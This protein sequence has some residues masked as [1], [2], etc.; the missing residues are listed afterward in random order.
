MTQL[1]VRG[2]IF[3][4][5]RPLLE[6]YNFGLESSGLSRMQ[7][8]MRQAILSVP[9]PSI[10]LGCRVVA[11]RRHRRKLYERNFTT[12]SYLRQDPGRPLPAADPLA[13]QHDNDKFDASIPQEVQNSSEGAIEDNGVS[14]MEDRFRKAK[15]RNYGSASRRVGRNRKPKE[16]INSQIP[17]WFVKNNVHLAARSPERTSRLSI[18]GDLVKDTSAS[19][20]KSNSKEGELSSREVDSPTSS[21]YILNTHIWKEVLLTVRGGLE[22]APQAHSESL[23]AR[24]SHVVL[25]CPKDGGIQF[26]ESIVAK[27][28]VEV[29]ADLITLD[30]QDIAEISGDFLNEESTSGPNRLLSL[31]YDAHQLTA[32]QEAQE[33]EEVAEEDEALEEEDEE[34]NGGSRSSQ[35]MPGFPNIANVSVIPMGGVLSNLQDMIR[36]GKILAG[37]PSSTGTFSGLSPM[38]S[39]SQD[40]P[41]DGDETRIQAMLEA[42]IS[43]A[44]IKRTGPDSPRKA[45]ISPADPQ[46]MQTSQ[47]ISSVPKTSRPLIIHVQDYKEINATLSGSRLLTQLYEVLQRRRQD[48][49]HVV[50]IGT[51]SSSDLLPALSK[52][53][54]KAMQSE[55]EA[56][57]SRTI[58]VI[59]ERSRDIDA[60]FIE[61]E[62][63]RTRHVNTR[64]LLHMMQQ[65]APSSPYENQ[66]EA[67][68][69]LDSTSEF[70]SGFSESVWPFDRV[71]RLA[72]VIIGAGKP[73]MAQPE[74][75]GISID[76]LIASDEVK[77]RWVSEEKQQEAALSKVQIPAPMPNPDYPKSDA[78]DKLKRIRKLCNSHERKLLSGVIDPGMI[79]L[80]CP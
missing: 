60:S 62:R 25:Q 34:E 22:L 47:E 3:R 41:P 7:T 77:Y 42:M 26:L 30:A 33:N 8:I 29:D 73:D 5:V 75:I 51:T 61:D 71:H 16:I 50:L 54:I 76:T 39:K 64:H 63:R 68:I 21:R 70:V 58:I 53:G 28:A 52:S 13:P 10:C 11:G 19:D 9:N 12:T 17:A 27:V 35:A 65:R 37:R 38:Y 36:S 44:H 67:N 74:N 14:A 79:C 57:S 49:Q 24:K 55:L 6:I 2:E 45:T 78:S 32:K 80:Q 56:S 4:R 69:R 66:L 59:P 18:E 20:K 40:S 23:P 1:N 15:E 72:Q 48:G 43:T 46:G 31:G